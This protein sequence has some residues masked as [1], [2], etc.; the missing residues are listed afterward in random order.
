MHIYLYNIFM[1]SYNVYVTFYY[2]MVDSIAD[3]S[4]LIEKRQVQPHGPEPVSLVYK[5]T[6]PQQTTPLPPLKIDG[7]GA[8]CFSP[9]F[10]LA[11]KANLTCILRCFV[12]IFMMSYYIYVTFYYSIVD[13]I[14]D[15][16]AYMC[17]Q[18]CLPYY[19]SIYIYD[20]Y[21]QR[22]NIL[23]PKNMNMHFSTLVFFKMLILNGLS[24]VSQTGF[25]LLG[26]L[27]YDLPDI[28]QI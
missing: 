14:P 13:S 6:G 21:I 20:A 18:C 23:R 22:Y 10:Y 28:C 24:N 27:F 7:S 3:T 26:T 25:I 9:D 4:M 1:M 17:R 16:R 2:C 8:V 15:T 19:I 12:N 5:A 11:A